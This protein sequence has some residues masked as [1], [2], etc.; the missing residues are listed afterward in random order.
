MHQSGFLGARLDVC[1]DILISAIRWDKILILIFFF[2]LNLAWAGRRE[3]FQSFPLGLPY[4]G[5]SYPASFDLQKFWQ[6]P[7][8]FTPA[9]HSRFGEM[10]PG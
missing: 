10:A 4:H 8:M 6:L 1:K 7:M 9:I 3:W 2:F 5:N